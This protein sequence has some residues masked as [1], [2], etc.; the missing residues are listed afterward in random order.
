MNML[1][2]T[3][4]PRADGFTRYCTDYFI[5]GAR[6]PGVTITGIDLTR[7]DI[8]PCKG[9]FHC[10]CKTPGQCI[11]RDGMQKILEA[12]LSADLLVCATPLYAYDIS[13]YMKIFI[14]R[15][16]PLLSPGVTY[17]ESGVDRNKIRY[18]EQGPRRMAAI[19]TGGLGARSH[20]DG[21]IMTLRNYAEGFD[22]VFAGALV[23]N[24]SYLLQFTDT[25]PKTIKTI[26]TGLEQ[27]GRTFALEGTIDPATI[28]KIATPLAVDPE[29]FQLYSNIYWEHAQEIFSCGGTSLE[30]LERTRGDIRI[31]MQEMASSV[32]PVTTSRIRAV[33]QFVFTDSGLSY[34]IT[35]NRGTATLETGENGSFDMRITTSAKI[36]VQ[37]IHRTIDPLKAMSSGD[38]RIEGDKELFRKFGR[39][40]PPPNL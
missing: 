32:D 19:I 11:Q 29:R 8:H 2:L 38:I 36:W 23:R 9:C 33:I 21:A 14:E 34:R 20:T 12:F 13:G 3:A 4:F 24:E 37:I 16:L 39:L 31:L 7:S 40:F 28:E 30:V 25:K 27:A 10:W 5:K 1:I 22:M 35:I 18:P 15:T 6:Q 17:A 26:Q